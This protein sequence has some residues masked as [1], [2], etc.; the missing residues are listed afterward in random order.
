LIGHGEGLIYSQFW[1]YCNWSPTVQYIYN[2]TQ[3]HLK[4][5]MK[6]ALICYMALVTLE[7]T[8]WINTGD[9]GCPI[10]KERYPRRRGLPG[11]DLSF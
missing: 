5:M 6:G 9:Q 8:F 2:D 7:L 3:T 11:R 1:K 10:F 4:E